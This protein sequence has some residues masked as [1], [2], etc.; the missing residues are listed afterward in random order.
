MKSF[1]K[2]L[3]LSFVFTQTIHAADSVFGGGPGG[4]QDLVEKALRAK[5]KARAYPGGRDEESLTVQS[6][7]PNPNRKMQPAQ[8]ALEPDDREPTDSND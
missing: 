2:I 7:L 8:E 1:V 3:I 4:G 5:V 6:Q